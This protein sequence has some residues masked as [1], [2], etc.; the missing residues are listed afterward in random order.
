M[1]R[2]EPGKWF[3][4]LLRDCRS[5]WIILALYIILIPILIYFYLI[6]RINTFQ[7]YGVVTSLTD[8]FLFITENFFFALM[9]VPLSVYFLLYLFRNDFKTNFIIRQKSKQIIWMKQTYKSLIFSIFFTFYLG[10]WTYIIGGN[11]SEVFINW[12]SRRSIYYLVNKTTSEDISFLKVVVMF[13]IV[14]V[15]I[16]FFINILFQLVLWLTNKTIIGWLLIFSIGCWD[17]FQHSNDILYGRLTINH[18]FWNDPSDIK[19][20]MIFVIC[21]ILLL[22]AVGFLIAKRKDFLNEN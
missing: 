11:F 10:F 12:D 19:N 21:I 18:N 14:S 17:I 6:S 2:F 15:I 5:Q 13:I 4:E 20:S 9:I 22:L 1:I 7:R 3:K 16:V 8:C